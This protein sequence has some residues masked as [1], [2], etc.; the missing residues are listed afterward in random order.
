MSNSIFKK[1]Y[2]HS[3][4]LSDLPKSEIISHV[5]RKKEA[6]VAKCGALVTWTPAD[7][8]GRPSKDTYIVK[9]NKTL[10]TVD[11][12]SP[13]CNPIEPTTFDQLLTEITN[14]LLT[15]KELFITN[16][17]LGADNSYSLKVKTLTNSPLT[18]LFTYNMFRKIT[19]NYSKSI[20]A[21]K[22]FTLL[23]LP[24]DKI[25]TKEYGNKLRD[26]NGKKSELIVAMDFDKLIGIVYGTSYLGA[27][28]KIM[29]TSMSYLLPEYEIL[30]LHCSACE[31]KE[32]TTALFLGLSGTG[33]TTLSTSSDTK[34]ISDDETAWTNG[35]ISNLENGVYAKLIRLNK[36][37]EPEI[38]KALF[39]KRPVKKHGCIIE[40]AMMYPNGSFDLDDSRYTENSRGSFPL[41]YH[42]NNKKGSTGKHPD[43]IF[44]L[45]CDA[46][47]VLPLVS[48]LS[49]SKALFWF[50]C[51]YT[52]KLAGTETGIIE[53]KSTFS[54]F[55]GEPFMPRLPNDYIELFKKKIEELNIPVFLVNTGW[56]K[57]PYGIG[58]RIDITISKSIINA[59]LS[60][61]ID[62]SQTIYDKRFGLDIITQCTGIK[63]NLL[64]PWNLWDNQNEY[65]K[66]ADKLSM[67]FKS[68]KLFV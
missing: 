22:E 23:V 61:K 35:G 39:N 51:A 41:N 29:F 53:P 3:N 47:G 13:S 64:I 14:K 16:R 2:N 25:N 52:S 63:N 4:I 38:F 34:I 7:S 20:F 32:G 66:R 50:Y 21:N 19:P 54:R 68:V 62:T 11:W 18:A 59:I 26:I 44:F 15:K 67:E 45:T 37:K 43:V 8:T 33:K 40:N 57:G 9:N 17:T 24:D 30:P 6:L 65:E 56:I 27:V 10:N 28:K 60:Q 31:S 55:F 5:I 42:P 49:N 12:N 36:K 48:K 1:L 46:N 58:E